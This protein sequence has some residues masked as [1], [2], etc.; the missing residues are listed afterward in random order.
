MVLF[1]FL[2][3]LFGT[4]DR[5]AEAEARRRAKACGSSAWPNAVPPHSLGPALD[6]DDPASLIDAIR[7][8]CYAH[9]PASPGRDLAWAA[10]LLERHV[11]AGSTA[12][13]REALDAWSRLLGGRA[14]PAHL[15]LLHALAA[16]P[17]L[18]PDLR[19]SVGEAAARLGVT[20][21][22]PTSHGPELG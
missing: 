10:P 20:H 15:Q 22:P 7:D 2:R 3:V 11:R 6:H 19:R 13:R 1:E 16:D 5:R 4:A 21:S 12:V 9:D 8:L 17:L 18:D 14:Q